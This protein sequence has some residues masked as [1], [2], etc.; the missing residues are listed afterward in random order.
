MKALVYACLLASLTTTGC[1]FSTPWVEKKEKDPVP[2][3]RA[4]VGQPT[5]RKPVHPP[6]EADA[7]TEE[8]AQE[9]LDRLELEINQAQT[10][11]IESGTA[12]R[13]PR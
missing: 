8:N 13:I 4:Q 11:G 9:M 1:I 2:K 5:I 6:V 10:N 3:A 7:I 12:L